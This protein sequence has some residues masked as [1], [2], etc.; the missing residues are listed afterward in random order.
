MGRLKSIFV[1]LLTLALLIAGAYLPRLVAAVVD[2]SNNGKLSTAAMESVRLEFR[3]QSAQT[4][5]FLFQKLAL[6]CGMKSIPITE[7]EASMTEEEV[8]A[9]VEQCME[10]YCEGNLFR[11]FEATHRQAEPYLAIDPENSGNAC[12]FWAVNFV[13]E[14]DPYHNLFLHLDDE[15]GKILYL[16][17]VN[18]DTKNYLL[19]PEDQRL[20]MEPFATAF[21]SQLGDYTKLE[22]SVEELETKDEATALRYTFMDEEAGS[23][24]IEFYIYPNGFYTSFPEMATGVSGYEKDPFPSAAPDAVS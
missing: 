6:E 11:W 17:Y 21:L 13:K 5:D 15:T 12:V 1:L 24:T 19:L 8:Y 4:P 2:W 18:Y 10:D 7:K 22:R 23:I 14:D 16:D 20:A 9:A 3:E